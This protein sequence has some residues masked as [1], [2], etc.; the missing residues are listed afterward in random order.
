[1]SDEEWKDR[2]C[3]LMES[4]P[5]NW[6]KAPVLLAHE[7]RGFLGS[8][9]DEGTEIDSGTNGTSGDLWVTIQGVEWFINIRKSNNQLKKEAA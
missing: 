8:I 1:M 9:K 6:D 5:V 4:L 3:W 2:A 7:I